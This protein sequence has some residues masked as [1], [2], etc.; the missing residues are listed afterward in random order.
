M[1]N[2]IPS[3]LTLDKG[4]DLQ[5]PKPM[6]EAGSLIDVLNYEQVDFQGQKRIDGYTRYD[7]TLTGTLDNYVVLTTVSANT[8]QAGDILLAENKVYG[9]AVGKD[10][11]YVYV[12]VINFTLAVGEGT[13]LDVMRDGASFGQ[14]TIL[15]ASTGKDVDTT[16]VHYDKLLQFNEALRDKTEAL[17]GPIAGLHWFRDRLYAVSSMYITNRPA[18]SSLY[19]NS[20]VRIGSPTGPAGQVVDDN[21]S[22]LL[23]GATTEMNVGDVIYITNPSGTTSLTLSLVEQSDRASFYMSR[24]EEQTLQE[25][26]PGNY[27][28][29]WKFRHL[30]WVVNFINGNV[31]YGELTSKNQNRGTSTIQGPTSVSGTSGSP[32]A[33]NQKISITNGQP[34]VNGW[35][36]N[37]SPNEYTLIPGNVSAADATYIY[38]DAFVS[39]DINGIQAPGSDGFSL[40]EY[41]PQAAIIYRG[42]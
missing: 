41:S 30:G 36:S 5:T 14:I 1:S 4:L 34:Q 2:L 11:S 25:D 6:A 3:A 20:T 40:Q 12:G 39:W 9:V 37:Q 10:S 7:G 27:D 13:T 21:G 15:T 19:I 18:G 33:L 24:T 42:S 16:S 26:S 28:F 29:G 22:T 31:P 32:L 23:I 35:K 8:I 38:A 17:P